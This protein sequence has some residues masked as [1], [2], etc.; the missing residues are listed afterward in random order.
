MGILENS[1]VGPER[2]EK[3]IFDSGVD[4]LARRLIFNGKLPE[5]SYYVNIQDVVERL[6]DLTSGNITQ[7]TEEVLLS[8]FTEAASA[9]EHRKQFYADVEVRVGKIGATKGCSIR[10]AQEVLLRLHEKTGGDSAQ[11]ND[12]LIT[13][14]FNDLQLLS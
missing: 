8:Q 3:E 6:N 4:D 9:R 2:S 13:R 7:V 11:V 14:A 12:E 1:I 5:D 10:D